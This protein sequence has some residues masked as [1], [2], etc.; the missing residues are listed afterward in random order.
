VSV[1]ERRNSLGREKP[2]LVA[3]G[4]T[5]QGFACEPFIARLSV[6]GRQGGVSLVFVDPEELCAEGEFQLTVR[7]G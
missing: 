4:V 5:A 3:S 6:L 1:T 2:S 7:V